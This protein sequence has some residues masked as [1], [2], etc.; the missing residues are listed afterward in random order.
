MTIC[1]WPQHMEK[2]WPT[3]GK[4]KAAKGSMMTSIC[5][6]GSTAGLFFPNKRKHPLEK[7]LSTQMATMMWGLG[8]CVLFVAILLHRSR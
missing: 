4:T 6:E 1:N 8:S 3:K 5:K 7:E 2:I